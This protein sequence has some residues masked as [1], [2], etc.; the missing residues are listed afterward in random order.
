MGQDRKT[1][2][3]IEVAKVANMRAQVAYVKGLLSGLGTDG[4]SRETRLV[5][6]MAEVFK[7][8]AERLDELRAAQDDM[9]D[10]IQALDEDLYA[11]ERLVFGAEDKADD[12][13]EDC[14]VPRESAGQPAVDRGERVE[15]GPFGG[16]DTA[17][18]NTDAL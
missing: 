12:M 13:A 6:E 1:K 10:Y 18:P 5:A 11:V 8:F 17:D 4:D 14:P 16:P 3:N 9:E 2:A 7:D 15:S